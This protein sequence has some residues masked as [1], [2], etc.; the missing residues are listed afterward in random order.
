MQFQLPQIDFNPHKWHTV[1]AILP[2]GV[3]NGKVVWL[4]KVQRRVSPYSPMGLTYEYRE[5]PKKTMPLDL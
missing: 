1:F 2:H 3:G 4:Q 5:L